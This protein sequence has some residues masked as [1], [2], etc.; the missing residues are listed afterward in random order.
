MMKA[1]GSV[2]VVTALA[3]LP[4]IPRSA[5]ATDFDH[6]FLAAACTQR[7]LPNGRL[8]G[9]VTT[10]PNGVAVEHNPNFTGDVVL[11]CNVD[12]AV[13]HFFNMFQIIAEDNTPTGSVTATLYQASADGGG[14][15]V[16]LVTVTTTDQPGVQV[17]QDFGDP[18][19]ESLNEIFY[20]YY[21]EIVIRRSSPT[22]VVRVYAVSLRDVL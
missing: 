11:Y 20:R 17:A 12:P 15:P 7:P 19:I 6:H 4:G 9:R 10:T 22:D 5:W 3:T 16:A 1:L 8:P 21:V 13:T 18:D 2:L 14:A